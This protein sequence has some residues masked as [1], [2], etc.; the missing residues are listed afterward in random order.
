[1]IYNVTSTE[2]VQKSWVTKFCTAKPNVRGF[3][4]WNLLH[5]NRLVSRILR[6]L[7]D[8]GKF[9]AGCSMVTKIQTSLFENCFSSVYRKRLFKFHANKKIV[10]P[11]VTVALC[12]S[13]TVSL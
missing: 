3:S 5:I 12:F 2:G 4:V 7:L 1:V 6:W 11:Y 13:F 8:L 10:L 9:V